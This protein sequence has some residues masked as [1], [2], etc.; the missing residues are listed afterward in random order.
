MKTPHPSACLSIIFGLAVVFAAH[1]PLLA[2][3]RQVVISAWQGPCVDGDFAANLATVRKVVQMARERSSDFLAFPETFLSGYDSR[4]KML[5]G[6]RAVDDPEL[7]SFIAE[8]AIHDI[9]I[10]VG[11]ARKVG[12]DVF[13]TVLGIQRGKLLGTY[14]KVM[15]TRGDRDN[16]KFKSGQDVPVFFAHGVH[17]AAV[18]CHDTSFPFPGLLAKL[19]GAEILFT[20]H[21]NAIDAR[22]VDDHRLAVRNSHVGLATLL[23]MIVVRS[24]VVV[25][26][27]PG[28]P[29]Y[30]DS[31]IMSPQGEILAGA[32]LFRTE[33]VTTKVGPE[34][35]RSPYVWADFDE[36]PSWLKKAVAQELTREKNP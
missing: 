17:F 13:N 16:L 25:T 4:E 7:A 11:L 21:Y 32:R 26:D 12:A 5:A 20:P 10:L 22:R 8:S 19:R 31:F 33:L 35:F 30:G 24:N 9:A 23:K 3:E 27:N 36:V 2:L 6:A 28:K 14:D 29:G 1:A 15:L 18:I 34:M